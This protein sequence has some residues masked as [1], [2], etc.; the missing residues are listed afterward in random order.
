MTEPSKAEQVLRGKFRD[1][2][3][4]AREE[5]TQFAAWKLEADVD[6]LM[7][8]VKEAGYV[9]LANDQT[10]PS[11]PYESER[12]TVAPGS[13]I[14]NCYLAAYNYQQTLLTL[15]WRKVNE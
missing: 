4:I 9:Q 2:I 5:G 12:N 15:H 11:L 3:W 10:C 8:Y 14:W 13:N 7:E 1:F 6:E